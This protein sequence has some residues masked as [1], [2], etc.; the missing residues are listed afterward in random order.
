MEPPGFGVDCIEHL[1]ELN[2]YVMPAGI[3]PPNPLEMIS[4]KKFVQGLKYLRERFDRPPLTDAATSPLS[5]SSA[6]AGSSGH[7]WGSPRTTQT[8]PRRGGS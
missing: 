7:T 5:N 8:T 1:P 2:L 3:I 4:S 6:R